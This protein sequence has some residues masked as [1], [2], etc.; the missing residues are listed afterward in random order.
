MELKNAISCLQQGVTKVISGYQ[1][2]R[3]KADLMNWCS[4]YI[5]QMG[6]NGSKNLL[7]GKNSSEG[8]IFAQIDYIV[9]W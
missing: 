7:H 8:P 2:R 3:N 5:Y 6:I 9:M 1:K 4:Y